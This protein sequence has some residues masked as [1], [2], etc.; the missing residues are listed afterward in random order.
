[1]SKPGGC[2]TPLHYAVQSGNADIIEYLITLPAV[3]VNARDMFGDT[4]L[5]MA[6]KLENRKITLTLSLCPWVDR[7]VRNQDGKIAAEVEPAA[8][9]DPI[10][11][12]LSCQITRSVE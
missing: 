1:M 9:C 10:N 11:Y 8:R 5:L 4:P 2:F 12:E 6:A 7:G 3:D